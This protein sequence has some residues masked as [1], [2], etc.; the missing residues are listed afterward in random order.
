MLPAVDFN[1]QFPLA[2]AKVHYVWANRKLA[3]ESQAAQSAISHRE[4]DQ[5][6]GFS[7]VQ[8]KQSSWASKGAIANGQP[9]SGL[10]PPSPFQGE[11]L[12]SP[13]PRRGEGDPGAPPGSG[14]G[15]STLVRTLIRSPT[16]FSLLGRRS[17]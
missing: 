8:T 3:D 17:D 7:A 10:R 1:D 5:V 15:A 11:G 9:S 2:A 13:S 4:P 6:F 14:E 12:I 16:T